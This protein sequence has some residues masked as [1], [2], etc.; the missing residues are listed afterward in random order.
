MA[1]QQNISEFVKFGKKI[2]AVGL[3]Y[4]SHIREQ[5]METPTEPVVFFKPTTS[6]I[7]PGQKIKIPNGLQQ[8]GY[9]VELGVVI[10]IGGTSI[11]PIEAMGH[12]A[13]YVLGLDMTNRESQYYVRQ[14][15]L[16]WSVAKGFDTSCP[17]SH[18][19]PKD[20]IKDPDDVEIW[21]KVNGE[22]K[23]KG[24]TKDM[25]FDISHLISWT[26]GHFTLEPGDLI[27]TGTP[28][29]VGM[30]GIGDVIEAGVADIVSVKYELE[31]TA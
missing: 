17:V 28:E 4:G 30:V 31:R 3:N 6:Y 19:I 18:F 24:S 7:T 22:M 13:G 5:N 25:I 15:G 11:R 10:G 14:K 21:L 16:P 29:G 2:V 1:S 8:L 23:Q 9:E 26:S 20:A 27:L 12:V